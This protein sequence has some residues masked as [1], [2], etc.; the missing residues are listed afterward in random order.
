M[1]VR[2]ILPGLVLVN[3]WACTTINEEPPG[4]KNPL[5]TGPEPIPVVVVPVPVPAAPTPTPPPTPTPNPAAPA[6][7]P[8]PT[9]PAPPAAASCPLPRGT[10]PGTNCP[11]QSPTF[12]REVEAALTAVVAENPQWFDLKKTRGGCENCYFILKPDNYVRRVAELITKDGLCGHYDG[13]ELAVKNSNSFNDQ[14]DI[15]TSDGY[16]RRQYGSYRSTCKPAWF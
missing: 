3:L 8:T 10:G 2:S 14:Y 13:E 4:R 6:P 16:I 12:L 15:F 11:L 1:R 5:P 9:T 7:A